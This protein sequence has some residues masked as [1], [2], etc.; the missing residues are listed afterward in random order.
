MVKLHLACAQHSPPYTH[1]HNKVHPT[2]CLTPSRC[3]TKLLRFVVYHTSKCRGVGAT[4]STTGG[5][6]QGKICKEGQGGWRY[7][8]AVWQRQGGFL[9][10]TVAC[11]F[12][13]MGRNASNMQKQDLLGV[14]YAPKT[15]GLQ[16]GT[17]P[18]KL[19]VVPVTFHSWMLLIKMQNIVL[20]VV[21]AAF[22]K[23]H[24]NP[25]PIQVWCLLCTP[26]NRIKKNMSFTAL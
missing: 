20:F 22:E 13:R 26:Q 21:F 25:Q 2:Y 9:S 5:Y 12:L 8:N 15:V 6:K 11:T 7:K 14:C 18:K 4:V 10:G 24:L 23:L 17:P 1:A 16:W 19:S 3:F